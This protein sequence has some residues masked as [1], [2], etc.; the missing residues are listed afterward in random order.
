MD[1]GESRIPTRAVRSRLL[2]RVAAGLLARGHRVTLFDRA[3]L[4]HAATQ[5]FAVYRDALKAAVD[6]VRQKVQAL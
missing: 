4:P 6:G 5:A 3:A 1:M 2:A